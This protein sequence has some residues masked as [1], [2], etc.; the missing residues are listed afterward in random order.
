[1]R[2]RSAVHQGSWAMLM[3]GIL[4][5]G[6]ASST[7]AQPS[8]SYGE[9]GEVGMSAAALA[10]ALEMYEKAVE[11]GDLVGAVVLVAR[12]GTVVL[13]EAI[14]MSDKEQGRPMVRNTLF[15]MASNTKP[16]V[17]TAIAQL[18][19]AEQLSYSDR[20]RT[21]IPEWDNDRAG[22]I[23][24][25][26]L[27]SHTGGL[28]INTLFLPPARANTS[29]QRAAARFGDV[30]A[31]VTPGTSYRYSNP[32]FNTLGALIEM[33]S[34]KLLEAYLDEAI[35]TPL[36]MDDSYNYREDH[37]LGGKRDRLGPMYYQ[38]GD[39]EAW[40][41]AQATT[42]PFARGSGGM[43]STAWD[44]A[45]FCQMILNGGSYD[46]VQVLDSSSV[47]TMV[48]PKTE[49]PV[50]AYGYGWTLRDGVISHGGSDGTD[51]WIDPDRGIVGLVFT[52]TPRGRPD[53]AEFRAL[54]NLAIDP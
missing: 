29:L 7:V 42:I 13:H 26:H 2:I 14:G 35:Y 51:A 47:A 54:V 36:G 16:V 41:P 20:I 17:A 37:P 22:S 52:Q 48:A 8:L 43:I 25:D 28:R 18:V 11:R 45:T 44:Y 32:G 9:P 15:H 10:E 34:G 33:R 23:T 27:L 12:N 1:M 5:A 3:L 4:W 40:Q 21:Y 49:T 31:E 6:L 53:V 50:G 46:G 39:D 30:G 24:I 19:E 38:R